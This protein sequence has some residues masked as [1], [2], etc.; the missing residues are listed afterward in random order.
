L[1]FL[2]IDGDEDLNA[3]SV[4]D[5]LPEK[6]RLDILARF[7]HWM[8]GQ[9][10]DDYHHGWSSPD[11]VFVTSSNGSKGMYVNASTDF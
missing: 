5:A 8:D 10:F 1:A 9:I 11:T 2:Q 4:F 3:K 7:Q 6:T